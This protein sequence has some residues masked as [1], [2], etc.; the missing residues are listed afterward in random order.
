M[1]QWDMPQPRKWQGWET[2]VA[3]LD[4][5]DA[6]GREDG[7]LLVVDRV[8]KLRGAALGFGPGGLASSLAS[9]GTMVSL[10]MRPSDFLKLT[11]FLRIPLQTSKALVTVVFLS[12]SPWDALRPI[13]S[14]FS[15]PPVVS[16]PAF[17]PSGEFARL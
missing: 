4:K 8:D 14:T 15:D 5:M 6:A 16:I 7:R 11:S 2:F 1:R 9:L 13:P 10:C 17:S 12:P 3:D